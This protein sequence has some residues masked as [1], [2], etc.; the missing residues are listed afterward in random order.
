MTTIEPKQT[1]NIQFVSSGKKKYYALFVDY[2]VPNVQYLFE[3][4]YKN[5]K[6]GERFFLIEKDGLNVFELKQRIKTIIN[7]LFKKG[8]PLKIDRKLYNT[9][10]EYIKKHNIDTPKSESKMDINVN[11]VIGRSK[12]FRN[13][14]LKRLKLNSKTVQERQIILE[15]LIKEISLS[16]FVID[17]TA[18]WNGKIT[19]TQRKTGTLIDKNPDEYE[20]I[21]V[22][23]TLTVDIKR[24][25]KYALFVYIHSNLAPYQD[26]ALY[27]YGVINGSDFFTIEFDS[28]PMSQETFKVKFIEKIEDLLKRQLGNQKFYYK[29]KEGSEFNDYVIQKYTWNKKYFKTELMTNDFYDNA[30]NL[31]YEIHVDVKINKKNAGVSDDL[32]MN[33]KYHRLAIRNILNEMYNS[34]T[35]KDDDIRDE[36]TPKT[37]Q[38]KKENVETFIKNILEGESRGAIELEKDAIREKRPTKVYKLPSSFPNYVNPKNKVLLFVMREQLKLYEKYFSRKMEQISSQKEKEI[39]KLR[40]EKQKKRRELKNIGIKNKRKTFKN[41]RKKNINKTIRK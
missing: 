22:S 38:V 34:D 25:N 35:K 8:E 36:S 9:A 24:V 19:P 33:C 16:K 18:K 37:I 17:N 31:K 1:Q 40:L 21:E 30:S 26:I 7:E 28:K 10:L 41:K 14:L 32:R 6:T 27:N 11:D 23:V 39:T 15:A 29:V 12:Q 4:S 13:K 5:P 3:N 2:T 20:K